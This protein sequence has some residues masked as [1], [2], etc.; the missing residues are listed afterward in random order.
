MGNRIGIFGGSFNPVHIGHI[1]V[2]TEVIRRNLA[3]EV[4]MM[5]CRQN[6]LKGGEPEL[7]DAARLRLLDKA[8][9]YAEAIGLVPAG[10]RGSLRVTDFELHLPSPS[11]T[12][13]TLRALSERYPDDEF[14]LIVGGDSYANLD[15]WKNFREIEKEHRII[16]YPRP[17]ASLPRLRAGV[18]LLEGVREYDV[19]ASR[20][21]EK[22]IDD[23]KIVMPWMDE[24]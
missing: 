5:P 24:Q 18:T 21:R 15:K 22:K 16:V 20:I 7:D 14:I 1:S 13:D 8:V 9:S 23:L 12:V 11:Y 10:Q 6:P 4:W 2:A 19:S 17:G 3:D